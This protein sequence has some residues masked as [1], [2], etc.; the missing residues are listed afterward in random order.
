M[1]Y[2]GKSMSIKSTRR[3]S[4]SERSERSKARRPAASSIGPRP[5]RPRESKKPAGSIPVARTVAWAAS[6]EP[7]S[8][9]MGTRMAHY[10]GIDVSKDWLDSHVL[11]EAAEQLREGAAERIPYT[12]QACQ[13]LAQKLAKLPVQRIVIEASGGYE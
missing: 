2:K 8:A 11:E 6:R 10:V 12:T 3:A 7:V 1:F 13:A 4:R 5:P 9:R